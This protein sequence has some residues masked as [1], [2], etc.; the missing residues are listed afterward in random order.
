MKKLFTFLLIAFVAISVNA[1]GVMICGKVYNESFYQLINQELTDAGYLKSGSVAYDPVNYKLTL[2]NADILCD[3]TII[4]T[5]QL[6]E[7]EIEVIGNC[8]LKTKKEGVNGDGSVTSS[9]ITALYNYLLNS[10]N[11]AIVNGDQDGDNTITSSDI[12]AVYNILLGS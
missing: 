9:D 10:D 1:A 4:E 2:N 8:T 5:Y 11:S 6:E 12:T 3:K 7:L